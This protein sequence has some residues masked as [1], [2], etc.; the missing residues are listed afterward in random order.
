MIV[1][2]LGEGQ[3]EVDDGRLDELNT[4]DAAV[5][6][7]VES[8]DEQAFRSALGTLLDGVRQHG[9]PVPDDSLLPSDAILPAPDASLAEVRQLLG[10]EGLIPG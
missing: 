5:E 2:V 6:A 7:A 9:R 1:R 4:L 3:L 10:D 8:G